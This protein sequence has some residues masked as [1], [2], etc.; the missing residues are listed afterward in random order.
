[1]CSPRRS[2]TTAPRTASQMKMS[3][4]SSSDHANGWPEHIARRRAG[5]E[6]HDLGHQQRGRGELD[7]D[8]HAPVERA[9]RTARGA[10]RRDADFLGELF[11]GELGGHVSHAI[12]LGDRVDVI[13]ASRWAA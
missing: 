6:Q 10:G 3:E 12:G 5:A 2:A 9:Q 11:A 13:R 8:G 4:A 1:M 7:D